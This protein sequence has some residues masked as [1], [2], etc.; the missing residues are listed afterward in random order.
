MIYNLKHPKK[1]NLK[2]SFENDFN[3]DFDKTQLKMPEI[4]LQ[5]LP[6]SQLHDLN[7][8]KKKKSSKH[9][10]ILSILDSDTKKQLERDE[11]LKLFSNNSLNF[12]KDINLA[13][14]NVKKNLYE[15]FL[16]RPTV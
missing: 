5:S 14:V 2:T 8:P 7:P 1:K 11:K 15:H 6:T 13:S 9:V 3:N 12:N 4:L 10:K 16:E